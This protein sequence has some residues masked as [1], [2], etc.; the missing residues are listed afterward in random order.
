MATVG[1][2]VVNLK[3]NSAD[4]GKKLKKARRT[5][6]KFGQALKRSAETASRWSR[7]ILLA[8]TAAAAAFVKLA[9]S[10]EEI[11]SKFDAV[12]KE[13]A[14]AATE[15]GD[16]LA[17]S[18]GRSTIAMKE[19]LSSMQD[20]FVPMGFARGEARKMAQQVVA[21]GIDL[22][23][24]NNKADDEAL[25]DLQSAL[26][27]NHETMR[28]YGVIITAATL[29][30]QLLAMGFNKSTKGATEQQK[31]LARLQLMLQMT[32]DAQGDAKRTAGS[33][34][35]QIKGLTGALRDAAAKIGTALIPMIQSAVKHLQVFARWAQSLSEQEIQGLI[36]K[37]KTLGMVLLAI[38]AAPALIGAITGIVYLVNVLTAAL[39]A[40]G[41]AAATAK[42]IITGGAAIATIAAAVATGYGVYKAITAL[43]DDIKRR[44]AE[45]GVP[46]SRPA[47][48]YR[49]TRG[50]GGGVQIERIPAAPA[51]PS[52][53]PVP[54]SHD[55][56]YKT[57]PDKEWNQQ[58]KQLGEQISLQRQTNRLLRD[59]GRLG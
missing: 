43:T 47:R 1:N 44:G 29:D 23:S 5:L 10:A 14:K 38:W 53:Q 42:M 33:L 48:Q 2:L 8:G 9:A 58:E 40:M 7:N 46:T 6:K 39:T 35:N 16:S 22:A 57:I 36:D 20:T 4:F 59:G 41:V 37:A 18:V 49:A 15:F 21:L 52:T 25:R 13:E 55:R 32:T 17:K 19:F 51:A 27:G 31:A 54:S 26:V 34:T 45:G 3:A 30:Q 50:P 24:F 11:Q 28:K 12:F 56:S